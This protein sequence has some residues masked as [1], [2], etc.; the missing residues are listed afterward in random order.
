M[1]YKKEHRLPNTKGRSDESLLDDLDN[2]EMH[3]L[4]N[5]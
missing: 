1:K 5:P 3:E 2:A 4:N